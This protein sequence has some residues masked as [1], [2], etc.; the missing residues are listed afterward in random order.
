MEKEFN[1]LDPNPDWLKTSFPRYHT[2]KLVSHRCQN[3]K[4]NMPTENNALAN[5]RFLL[6]TSRSIGD[7]HTEPGRSLNFCEYWLTLSYLILSMHSCFLVKL[8]LQNCSISQVV[9]TTSLHH[10]KQNFD[11]H[12]EHKLFIGTPAS[13]NFQSFNDDTH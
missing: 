9:S 12:R 4:P 10:H 6:D 3:L 13:H 2:T 1:L 5:R 11:S 8:Q 7:D